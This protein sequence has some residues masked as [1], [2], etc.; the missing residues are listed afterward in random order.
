[1]AEEKRGRSK[2]AKKIDIRKKL[3]GNRGYMTINKG[4]P[5]KLPLPLPLFQD[6][7]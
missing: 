1:M 3:S 5:K 4:Q 2:Y 6:S 7:E